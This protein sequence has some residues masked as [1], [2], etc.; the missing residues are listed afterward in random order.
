MSSQIPRPYTLLVI[1]TSIVKDLGREVEGLQDPYVS[2]SE[3][4]VKI[5]LLGTRVSLLIVESSFLL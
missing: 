5:I 4:R 3:V 2:S 1:K